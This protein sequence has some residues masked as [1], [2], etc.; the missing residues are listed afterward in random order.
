MGALSLCVALAPVA[1][2]SV[3]ADPVDQWRGFIA[4]ASL[5]FGVPSEWIVRVMRAESGGRTMRGGRPI[6]SAKGAIG[7]MQLMP[8]TWAEMRARLGLGADPDDPR[9]NIL[10]GTAYL[11]LM[12]DRFGY[13]GLFAAYNAGPGRYA[14]Y[15]R[16]QARLPPE[17]IAYLA[18]VT[19][20]APEALAPARPA[21]K[22]AESRAIDPLFAVRASVTIAAEP[23]AEAPPHPPMFAI[24]RDVP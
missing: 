16:G 12:Y 19:G 5:H 1:A 3:A 24:R 18:Q 23:A 14:A 9:D 11:R 13:P 21:P 17:T 20:R 15:L 6:R 2:V 10:A 4:E 8:G 22:E 7:L